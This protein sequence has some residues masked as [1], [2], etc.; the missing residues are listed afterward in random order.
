VFS[1]SSLALSA[2]TMSVLASSPVAEG[3]RGADTGEQFEAEVSRA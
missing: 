3:D 1:L 2:G